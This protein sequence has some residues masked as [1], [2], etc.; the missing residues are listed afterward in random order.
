MEVSNLYTVA[1][2]E[3]GAEVQIKDPRTKKPL[4]VFISVKG[5]DSKAFQEA[6]KARHK[7]ELE[8][9]AEKR[10]VD[11]TEMDLDMLVALTTGWR[12]LLDK[13]KEYEFSPDRCR[14]LYKESPAIREQVDLFIANRRNFTSG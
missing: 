14:K 13:G 5:I 11:S 12:G 4:D 7:A 10:D 3:K 2:S 1:A 6:K 8:A 9:I